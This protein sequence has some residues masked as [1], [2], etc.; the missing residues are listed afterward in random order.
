MQEATI[1]W[2][3]RRWIALAAGVLLWGAVAVAAILYANRLGLSPWHR[4]VT[5]DE[6]LVALGLLVRIAVPIFRKSEMKDER[7][8][9]VVGWV[10]EFTGA[11]LVVFAL[12]LM[13][14]ALL[15]LGWEP[16]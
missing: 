15:G 5:W 9:R 13:T 7:A 14:R 4:V 16:F 10:G 2:F 8:Q 11:L 12:D 6:W 3:R 1:Q